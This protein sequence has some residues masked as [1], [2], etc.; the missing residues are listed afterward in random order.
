MPALI[1]KIV[2]NKIIGLKSIHF[3][4]FRNVL[5]VLI[6]SK[7]LIKYNN[8]KLFKNNFQFDYYFNFVLDIILI[9]FT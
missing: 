1:N 7:I 2:A 9:R 8:Y 3:I 5:L 6:G 4:Y